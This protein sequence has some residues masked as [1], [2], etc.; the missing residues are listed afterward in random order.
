M[1][2]YPDR[3]GPSGKFVENSTKL[4]CLEI[5]DYLVKYSRVLWLLELQIRRGRKVETHE[6]SVNSKRLFSK[7][8]PFILILCISGC[9][10]VPI[11]PVS[12][13]LLYF[14]RK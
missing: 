1:A 7:E 2:N 5:A 8:N 9:L 6:R 11:N 4:T 13:V 3:L 12:G 14:T 10:T